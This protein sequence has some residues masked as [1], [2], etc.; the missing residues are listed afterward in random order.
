M[1][2]SICLHK[3]SSRS[4]IY[5]YHQLVYSEEYDATGAEMGTLASTG[6]HTGHSF[7][8]IGELVSMIGEISSS[9]E[10]D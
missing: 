6:F 9:D 8:L 3:T 5:R 10:Q 7:S 1:K 2:F 4:T